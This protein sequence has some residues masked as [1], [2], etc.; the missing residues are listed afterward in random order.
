M[1]ISRQGSKSTQDQEKVKP[2]TVVLSGFGSVERG[3]LKHF[4]QSVPN[5]IVEEDMTFRVKIVISNT[6]WSSKYKVRTIINIP[7]RLQQLWVYRLS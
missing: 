2:T 4:L 7:I 6:V 1:S 3:E 5:L